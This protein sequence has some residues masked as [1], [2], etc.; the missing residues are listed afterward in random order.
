MK[1]MNLTAK[2]LVMFSFVFLFGVTVFGQNRTEEWFV[3]DKMI[4]CK[5]VALQKCLVVREVNSSDW[6]YFYGTIRGLKFRENYTQRI[7]VRISP[8]KNA[9]QDVSVNDYRLVKTVSRSRTDGNTIDEAR[10]LMQNQKSLDLAERKWTVTE[11]KGEKIESG[12]AVL[13]F[14]GKDKS[15]GTKICNGIGGN[16]ELNG[17]N[18]KFTGIVGTMMYCGEPLQPIEDKFKKS[19]EIVTRGEQNGNDLMFFAGNKPVLKLTAETANAMNKPLEETKWA[20]LEIGNEKIQ[21]KGQIPYLQFGDEKKMYSGFSGCNRMFGKYETNENSINFSEGGMTR[22]ACLDS[23]V[24]KIE[25]GMTQALGKVNR[26]EI[27]N[28][29][30]SLFDGDKVLLKLMSFTGK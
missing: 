22:M 24:Q 21:L 5:G 9:P 15:F 19:I 1:K 2:F 26:Y 4:D 8:R 28:G 13:Q 16:Y 11:I 7:R 10:N 29:A 12:I 18:I 14:N 3:A 20:L 27:K 23:E 6:K 17:L 30:L 25:T